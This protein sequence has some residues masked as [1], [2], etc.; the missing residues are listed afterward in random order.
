MADIRRL[1]AHDVPMMRGLNAM[2]AAAFEDAET[3]ASA[4][5][6]DDYLA[7]LLG[8]DGVFALAAL[9]GDEVIGGLV[10]MVSLHIDNPRPARGGDRLQPGDQRRRDPAPPV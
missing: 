7:D 3:Y 5:P 9:D 1:T 6:P 4:P 10:A 2:F 8:R